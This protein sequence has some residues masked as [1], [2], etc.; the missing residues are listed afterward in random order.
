MKP[1]GDMIN[2]VVKKRNLG[3][4]SLLQKEVLQDKDVQTFLKENASHLN[5]AIVANSMANLYEFYTQKRMPTM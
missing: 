5:K 3:N 2:N 4:F 1:I